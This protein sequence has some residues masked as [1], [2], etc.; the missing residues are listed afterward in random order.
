MAASYH[1]GCWPDRLKQFKVQCLAQG[2][3]HMWAEEGGYQ[4]TNPVIRGRS[5]LPP[6]SQPPQSNN[7]YQ[8][9]VIRTVVN[10]LIRF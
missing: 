2:H 5:T 3:F 8:S 4:T 6:E 10:G 7:Q 1:V 9:K